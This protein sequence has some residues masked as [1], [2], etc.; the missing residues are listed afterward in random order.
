M[1]TGRTQKLSNALEAQIVG[2]TFEALGGHGISHVLST[3]S[4]AGVALQVAFL[5]VSNMTISNGT[6]N[7]LIFYA[8]IVSITWTCQ[9]KQRL[10]KVLF[11]EMQSNVHT[12]KIIIVRA[13]R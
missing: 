3:V 12:T 6:P 4:V 1:A 10:T 13:S 2:V 7:S 9:P 8:N 5:L 11:M